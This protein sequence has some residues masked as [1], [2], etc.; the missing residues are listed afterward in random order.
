MTEI[1]IRSVNAAQR[2]RLDDEDRCG[3]GRPGQMAVPGGAFSFCKWGA[4]KHHPLQ[5]GRYVRIGG[6]DDARQN[7][8]WRDVHHTIAGRQYLAAFFG[9]HPTRP[10]RAPTIYLGAVLALKHKRR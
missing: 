9:H 2:A 3:H 7:R 5:L 10:P 8:L 1:E 6:L 4:H